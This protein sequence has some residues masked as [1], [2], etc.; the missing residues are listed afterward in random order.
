MCVQASDFAVDE[1]VDCM[2]LM[3]SWTREGVGADV[4]RMEVRPSAGVFGDAQICR[5]HGPK[6]HVFSL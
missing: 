6:I 4:D 3:R 1:E 2:K 5:H